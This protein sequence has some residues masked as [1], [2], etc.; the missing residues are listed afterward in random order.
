MKLFMQIWPTLKFHV[1]IRQRSKSINGEKHLSGR[2]SIE[3]NDITIKI[4][5][6]PCSLEA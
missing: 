4:T 1:Y 2:R 5:I 3:G 6:L